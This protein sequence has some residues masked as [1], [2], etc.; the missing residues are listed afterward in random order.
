MA[1]RSAI[2]TLVPAGMVISCAMA[3]EVVVLDEGFGE[4]R[5]GEASCGCASSWA[6]PNDASTSRRAKTRMATSNR[7]IIAGKCSN[8]KYDAPATSKRSL[9][10]QGLQEFV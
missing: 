9:A 2:G 3:W 4:E 1:L 5:F 10:S 7:E 8:G 6:M